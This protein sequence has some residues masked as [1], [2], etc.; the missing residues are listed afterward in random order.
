MYGAVKNTV[1]ETCINSITVIYEL[2]DLK[3]LVSP[4]KT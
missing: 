3:G 4:S 1:S 2:R